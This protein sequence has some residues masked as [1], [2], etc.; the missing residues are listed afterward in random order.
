MFYVG[1]TR[2]AKHGGDGGGKSHITLELDE[3]I[4]KIEGVEH[5]DYYSI[6]KLTFYSNKGMILQSEHCGLCLILLSQRGSGV[7][8]GI[9]RPRRSLLG[10]PGRIWG[11]SAS[12]EARE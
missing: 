4:T 1:Q 3:F 9:E 12:R 10:M 11:C 8:M 2:F 6:S 5:F 7:L